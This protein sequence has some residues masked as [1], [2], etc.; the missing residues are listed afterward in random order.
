[1]KKNKKKKITKKPSINHLESKIIRLLKKNYNRTF[2]YKQVCSKLIDKADSRTRNR[3]IQC[4]AKLAKDQKIVQVKIGAFKW[5]H[6]QEICQGTIDFTAKG[7]AYVTVDGWSDDVFI[8]SKHTGKALQ[9][10]LVEIWMDPPSKHREKAEGGVIKIL[11]RNKTQFTG[12]IEIHKNFAFVTSM[13]GQ[14]HKDFFIPNNKTKRAKNGQLVLLEFTDWPEKADSPNGKVIDIL[15]YPEEST[16]Q[17]DSIL[18]QYDLPLTFPDEVE[19]FVATLD[20]SISESEVAKRRDLRKTLTFTIDPKDAKD[21]DDALSFKKLVNGNFEIGIHIADVSHYVK[22][23]TV[24]DKEAYQRATSVYLVDRV[25]PM[26]PEILSNQVCS[27][28]PNEDKYTFSA[29]FEL[30][31]TGKIYNKWFGRTVICSDA[32]F[33]YEEAQYMIETQSRQIPAEVTIEGQSFEASET[34]CEAIL[35]MNTL[36]KQL[37]TKR[38]AQGAFSFD[39]TEVRFALDNDFNPKEVYFKTSK[40]ANKLIEEFMLLANTKVSEF[41]SSQKPKK[42]FIYRVHDKPDFDKLLSLQSVVSNFGYH[43]DLS[44]KQHI[45]GSLNTLLSDIK[46]KKE[47]NMIDTLAIRSMSKAVYSATNIG[48]YG[49]AFE[50]YS[51]FTSPIRRYPDVI[52]HRLLQ[53]YLDKGTSV[54]LE[55]LEEECKH[56]S[57]REILASNA[58]RDSVKYM[59]IKYMQNFKDEIFEGIITGVTDWGIYVE[60]S[61]NKCEGMLRLKDL[62]GD[63]F[64]YDAEKYAAIGKRT[65]KTYTLGDVLQVK[66]KSTDLLKRHLD[67]ILIDSENKN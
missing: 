14:L 50:H 48:H 5:A 37:R 15:G 34:I 2:N 25:V 45:T 23:D 28:R 20:L 17:M 62:K 65:G 31:H 4:L 63:Y 66:V 12:I 47:Q 35:T 51:H 16:A 56:C 1:M 52:A 61:V 33:S 21:F 55:A 60:I 64:Y 43:L 59:Q 44:K 11:K 29:I 19:A 26:L 67:F 57:S 8:P 53:H 30:D 54:D 24:L 10:D 6:A 38:M 32:R 46:G 13:G 9:G 18:L 41:I 49:L 27:L 36:A 58:E 40:D 42:S 3:I 22:E 39:K 7:H